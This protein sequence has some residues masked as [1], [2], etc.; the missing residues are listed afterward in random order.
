MIIQN[1]KCFRA[2]KFASPDVRYAPLYA[3][4]WNCACTRELIDAQLDEMKRLGIRAFY[5]I[6]EP[7]EFRPT[8]MPT[9]LYPDYLTEGY[10]EMVSYALRGG[11]ARGMYTGSTTRV[12]GPPAEPAVRC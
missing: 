3:W 7:R 12:A 1:E 10:F 2:D 9:E 4:V 5:I 8:F 6:P 11:R